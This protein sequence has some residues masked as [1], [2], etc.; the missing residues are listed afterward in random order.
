MPDS[1]QPH[2]LQPIRL[3]YPWDIPGRNTRVGCHFLFQG[4]FLTKG[5][6]WGLLHCRQIL[7]W[8]SYEVN[9][10]QKFLKINK[11][12]T[13]HKRILKSK[14]SMLRIRKYKFWIDI[15][16]VAL[17]LSHIIIIRFSILKRNYSLKYS[18]YSCKL[19]FGREKFANMHTYA[20]I[21]NLPQQ[22]YDHNCNIKIYC[23]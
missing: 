22:F 10:L 13:P 3:L 8:L 1:L 21:H 5:L 19:L 4:I 23:Y 16:K 2:G 7:Y 20:D 18:V 15:K 11:K 17:R 6:N 9:N 14:S 12:Q